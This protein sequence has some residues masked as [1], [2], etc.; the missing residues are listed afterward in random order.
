MS[1]SIQEEH[2]IP[3]EQ[4]GKRLD[5]VAAILLSD[6]SRSRLQEWIKLGH[7]TV[8]G[9]SRRPRDKVFGGES[10]VLGVELEEEERWEPQ[11]IDLNVVYSDDDIIVIN[12]PVGFVVH[13]GAGVPNGTLLN[14]LLYHFPELATLPRA[15]LSLIHI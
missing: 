7:I 6:Y 14:G 1:K 10:L 8:D 13:P 5:Q 4:A 2:I 11:N 9:Q 3:A 12:K 15:G